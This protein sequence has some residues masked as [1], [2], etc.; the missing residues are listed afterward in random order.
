MVFGRE[1]YGRS[2]TL[3]MG[4]SRRGKGAEGKNGRGE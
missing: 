1:G 2:R 3:G 4:R